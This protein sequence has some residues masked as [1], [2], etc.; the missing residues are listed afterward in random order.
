MLTRISG[1]LRS[2]IGWLR[3]GYPDEAPPTGYSPLIALFGP[4]AL[5][6]RQIQHIVDELDGAPADTTDIKVAIT[7]ATDRLPTQAQIR[8]VAHALPPTP[9]STSTSH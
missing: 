2:V 8:T 6:P 5:T 9:P 1:A 3:S 4:M 7:K